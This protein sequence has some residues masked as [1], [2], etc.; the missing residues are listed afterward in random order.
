MLIAVIP[1]IFQRFQVVLNVRVFAVANETPVRQRRIRRFEIDFVVRVDLLLHVEVEAVGVVTFIGYARH[2]AELGG[3]QTAEAVTEVFTWRAVQTKAVAGLVF[4]LIHGLAQTLHNRDAFSAKLLAVVQ[5]F[6]AEQRVNG[7]MDTNVA[8]RD[9]RT[10][11]FKDFRHV[12][13][14]FQPHAA[15]AFHIQDRRDAGFHAFKAGDTGHQRLPRQRQTFIQQFPECGFVAFCF[16]RDARQ[17]KANHAQVVTPVV[18]LFA[19]FVLPHAEE[20]AAAHWR[21][22]RT[23]DFDHLIV[24][25]NV[26]IHALARALQRQLFNVVVR[27]AKLVVQTIA[28]SEDQFREHGGFAIFTQTGD[29]V[30][31]N[32]RLDQTRLP[33]GAEAKTKGHERRLAVSGVQRVNFVFQRLEGVVA[34]FFGAR[35]RISFGIRN[36]PLIGG[37][38]V[39]VIAFG[40]KRRQHFVDTVNGGAAINMAGDL[41][42]N[43]RGNGSGG[44]DRFWRFDLGV[45]HLKALG[46][47]AFQVDQHTVEH[48]EERRIVEIV[49]V[50]IAALMRLYYVTRQ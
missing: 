30:T 49:I 44:R 34:L 31:Q 1:D 6:A 48:R 33:T 19:V 23:G 12:V 35:T 37:F 25:E 27:I 17:V 13:V 40:D 9:G 10:T 22:E 5:V 7:F 26:R 24:V 50:D 14:R 11:I 45:T 21:F 41:R 47:H 18:D 39:L 42:D 43:L 29:T 36:L 15:G 4:P 16:Q 38:A 20:A 8:Q 32:R 46:Q 28:D 3:I 2:H